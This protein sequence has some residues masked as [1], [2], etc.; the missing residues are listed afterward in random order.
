MRR[1]LNEYKVC[2][3][4]HASGTM[5]VVLGVTFQ[6][7]SVP[8]HQLFICYKVFWINKIR[9]NQL[10]WQRSV[11]WQCIPTTLFQCDQS[12]GRI[13]Y[14]ILCIC[15]YHG[16]RSISCTAPPVWTCRARFTRKITDPVNKFYCSNKTGWSNKCDLLILVVFR[17]N[18]SLINKLPG[19]YLS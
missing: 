10:R 9:E 18:A 6:I 4:I 15:N 14:S 12:W 19:S 17:A 5:I 8:D 7:F 1:L 3:N 2:I 11:S 16:K 13:N